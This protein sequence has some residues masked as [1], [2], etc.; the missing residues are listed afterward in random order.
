ME[1]GGS[2]VGLARFGSAMD[3]FAWTIGGRARSGHGGQMETRTVKTKVTRWSFVPLATSSPWTELLEA[4]RHRG[5]AIETLAKVE[6]ARSKRKQP[7]QPESVGTAAQSSP[8]HPTVLIIPHWRRGVRTVAPFSRTRQPSEAAKPAPSNHRAS[9]DRIPWS[10][11]A[12]C[13]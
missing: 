8:S 2:L 10:S 4:S 5:S 11:L 12:A 13:V 6:G 9:A 3:D 7:A 1:R